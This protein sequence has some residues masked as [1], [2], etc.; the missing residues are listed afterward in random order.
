MSIFSY[1]NVIIHNRWISFIR[2]NT[3]SFLHNKSLVDITEEHTSDCRTGLGHYSTKQE[4]MQYQCGLFL[5]ALSKQVQ[6]S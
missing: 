6:L 3:V 1:L 4:D 2:W 5:L